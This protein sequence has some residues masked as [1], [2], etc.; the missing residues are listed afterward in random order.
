MNS[1][2]EQLLAALTEMSGRYPEWRFGQ[3][4]ANVTDW[5][6]QPADAVG[7]AEA[8]WEVEDD[9]LIATI[10]AHLE[11]RAKQLESEAASAE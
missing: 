9:E 6:R 7:A 4:I 1:T 3:M 8:M 11:R 10:R 5:A 2:R